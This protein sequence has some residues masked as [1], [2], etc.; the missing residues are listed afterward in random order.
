MAASWLANPVETRRV[1]DEYGLY[2]KH[3]LGQNFLVNDAVIA[4]ILELAQ[5]SP[6]DVALEVGPGIGTLTVALLQ[7]AGAVCAIEADHELPAVLAQ[8]CA[9]DGGHLALIR[10]DA[11]KV[12]PAEIE[13]SLGAL[14]G[15]SPSCRPTMLVSNLPYQVAATIVLK[16]FQE[17][18]SLRRAVV[19]VQREVADRMAASPGNR[20]YGGYTAKLSL[21]GELT[22]RFEVGP[23]NFMPQPH[24][25][26]AVVRIDRCA[27]SDSEGIALA[28]Q[29][30][31]AVSRVIDAAFAQRRKTIRNSMASSGFEKAVLDEAFAACQISPTTRAESLAPRQFVEL[32]E[33]LAAQGALV[34]GPGSDAGK[35]EALHG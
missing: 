32:A 30:L 29:Q 28:P 35:E 11:L 16:S 22:G 31:A 17:L 13:D 21:Y 5:L 1:L 7:S 3:R 25:D 19:M 18:P 23:S 26:S 4:H 12:S 14:D 8:T 34:Y 20:I 6:D 15:R 10:K 33:A 24:V 9:R 2:A 27:M